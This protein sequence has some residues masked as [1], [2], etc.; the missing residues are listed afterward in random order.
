MAITNRYKVNGGGWQQIDPDGVDIDMSNEAGVKAGCDKYPIPVLNKITVSSNDGDL[1]KSTTIYAGYKIVQQMLGSLV[2]TG[3]YNP[4][5]PLLNTIISTGRFGI[6][7]P[8]HYDSDL[9]RWNI[10]DLK[11]EIINSL[12]NVGTGIKICVKI[13]YTKSNSSNATAYAA[14]PG[15][16]GNF[17]KRENIVVPYY[18]EIGNS[19]LAS[20]E[21]VR[22]ED[23]ESADRRS[24]FESILSYDNLNIN[25]SSSIVD[26]D[27]SKD[28][29]V[30]LMAYIGST[31]T[32]NNTFPILPMNSSS[33]TSVTVGFETY[34][35]TIT[36]YN[37]DTT[38]NP[39]TYNDGYGSV[40]DYESG[41]QDDTTISIKIVAPV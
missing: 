36:I 41:T 9:S 26:P 3:N 29:T 14:I 11:P 12:I 8:A 25:L 37:T 24:W 4:E 13:D 39:D 30:T 38:N 18:N 21:M 5:T 20:A 2:A 6:F 34:N 40:A 1:V 27:T 31:P 16:S 17:N 10:H 35:P 15:A 22:A 23:I 19:T 32:A 33:K 7:E 28:I